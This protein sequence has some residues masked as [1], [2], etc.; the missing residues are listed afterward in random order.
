[1]SLLY[2]VD[3]YNVILSSG[4]FEGRQLKDS[5]AAFIAY[6]ERC[7][8]HG[9][10]R[11]KLIVVFD[12]ASQVYGAKGSYSFEVVFTQGQ[13]ADEKI[14]EIVESSNDTKNMVIVTNDKGISSFVR[15]CGA[16]VVGV[17]EFLCR[18]EASAV[19]SGKSK[20]RKSVEKV[21]LNIVE[22]EAITEELK[23]IWLKKRSS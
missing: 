13:T 10:V 1:M 6:L 19:S 9:S 2:L 15:Q 5:R 12:G 8:P 14:K 7:R 16:K 23:L 3:G 4:L 20:T 18:R 17:D 11:N 22:R 21:S